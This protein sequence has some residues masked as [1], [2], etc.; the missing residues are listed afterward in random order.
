MDNINNNNT[1]NP[2]LPSDE[3][4]FLI[5]LE[6]IQNLSNAKYLEFLAQQGYLQS[7]QFLTY[8]QYLQYWKESPYIQYLQ[9]P[10]CLAFLDALLTK[11]EFRTQLHLSPFIEHIHIQ[12]GYQWLLHHQLPQQK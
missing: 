8:L 10:Q 7:E 12:Q 2:P 9:Y 3:E 5:D 1:G 6:F 11:P 4:R